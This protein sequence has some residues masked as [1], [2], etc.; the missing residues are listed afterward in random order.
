M[1]G[2]GLRTTGPDAE[3]HSLMPPG[4]S[5]YRAAVYFTKQ[6][7]RQ[8][9]GRYDKQTFCASYRSFSPVEPGYATQ[10]E[11]LASLQDHRVMSLDTEPY[12]YINRFIT[13]EAEM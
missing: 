8:G 2:W 12:T 9:A 6:S 4:F 11:V 7:G 3:R 1:P 5:P 10:T 13:V